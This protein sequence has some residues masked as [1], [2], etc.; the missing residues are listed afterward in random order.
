MKCFINSYKSFPEARSDSFT[1]YALYFSV[2][3]IYMAILYTRQFA[4]RKAFSFYA[5][6]NVA[7]FV[8]L[9]KVKLCSFA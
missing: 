7:I 8:I 5:E 3:G 9:T 2:L 6:R 1:P 4:V